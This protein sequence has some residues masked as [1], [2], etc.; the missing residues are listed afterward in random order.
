MDHP[1]VHFRYLIRYLSRSLSSNK[2]FTTFPYV[3]KI[4]VFSTSLS[5]LVQ[6]YRIHSVSLK[7]RGVELSLSYWKRSRTL[8]SRRQKLPSE[9]LR[10]FHLIFLFPLFTRAAFTYCRR[11]EWKC[12]KA[13]RYE[14]RT[15]DLGFKKSAA[16]MKWNVMWELGSSRRSWES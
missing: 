2:I 13:H 9:L 3:R 16:K 10:P 11:A 8:R 6:I 14:Y 12:R 1:K 7:S 4:N 15:Q 5:L